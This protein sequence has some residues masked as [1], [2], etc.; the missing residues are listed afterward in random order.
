MKLLLTSA[1]VCIANMCF[2]QSKAID[3]K[4]FIGNDLNNDSATLVLNG[5]TIVKNFKVKSTMIS[6]QSLII[7]QN[8]KTLSVISCY[9][10]KYVLSKIKIIKRLLSIKISVNTVWKE[11]KFDLRKGKFFFVELPISN[12]GKKNINQLFIRQSLKSPIYF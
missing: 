8:S 11:F 9:S 1:F 7:T 12:D 3:F 10:K 4:I 2:S 5:I 6:P